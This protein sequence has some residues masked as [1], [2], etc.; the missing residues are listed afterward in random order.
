MKR[1]IAKLFSTAIISSVFVIG[2]CCCTLLLCSCNLLKTIKA[3]SVETMNGWQFQYN[4]G[5]NDYSVFFALCDKNGKHLSSDCTVD[6]RIEN[7]NG[8]TV[9]RGTKNITERDFG[10]YSSQIAGERFLANVRIKANE[11]KKGTSASGKVYF[12]VTKKNAFAFDE[13]NCTAL[14]CLPIK[15]TQLSV[16]SL[17]AEIQLKDYLGAISSKIVITDVQYKVDTALGTPMMSILVTG[18][19]TFGTNNGLS[20]DSIT[21]K[22]YD[23]EG[24]L[25][26]SG[27]LYLGS[28]LGTG[29]KFKETITVY[30]VTP[31]E[32]YTLKFV[33]E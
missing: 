28:G 17:P 8:E 22:L 18:E 30:D 1:K 14:Y 27:S 25:S 4:E 21:Y 20:L 26:K 32:T 7:D 19:K 5:T 6:I 16:D 3:S 29:D 13:V 11:I 2:L 10:T 23:S 24:F 9:Y 33:N 15:D 31:G 12:T